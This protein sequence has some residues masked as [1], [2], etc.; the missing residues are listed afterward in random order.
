LSPWKR[1]AFFVCGFLP[2]REGGAEGC[3]FDIIEE[4][5]VVEVVVVVVVVGSIHM[6]AGLKVWLALVIL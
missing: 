1:Q 3:E 5:D 2:D 4:D 6:M